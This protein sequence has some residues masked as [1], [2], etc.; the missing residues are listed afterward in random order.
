MLSNKNIVVLGAAGL[1]GSNIIGFLVNAK[2]TVLAVDLDKSR[3]IENLKQNVPEMALDSVTCYELDITNK[4]LVAEFFAN[5]TIIDGIVNASYPRNKS[6]GADFVD[7][8]LED[9]NENVS[10]HLGSAF[11]VMQE[12]VKLFDRTERQLSLINIASIYGVIAPKF[13]IYDGTN[14]TMPV[15]YAAIKAAILHL[16][17]YVVS[18]VNDSRFRANCVSP[19]GILD[20]QPESFVAAYKKKTHGTGMLNVNDILGTIAFLLSDNSQFIT[21]QNIVVDDGFTL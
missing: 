10:M 20:Q 7:V 3:I 19:G 5:N 16:T 13:D 21:G 15:E 4:V 2:A 11:L 8:T 17:K 12:A 9:F 18:Y 6:Y 14:M 1:L